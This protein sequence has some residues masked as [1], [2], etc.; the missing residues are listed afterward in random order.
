M[1]QYQEAISQADIDALLNRM[2]AF[3]DAMTKE[4]HLLNRGFVTA[5]GG[6]NMAHQFDARMLIQTQWQPNALELIFVGVTYLE[7]KDASEYW[8]AGGKFTRDLK[9]GQAQI[10][11]EFDNGLSIAANRLFWRERPDWTG[12]AARLGW[13]MP[14]PEAVP[15]HLIEGEWRQ[16]SACADAF[17]CSV[18]INYVRCPSCG[19]L[20]ELES[21]G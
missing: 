17:E 19:M 11:F 12:A 6:M 2:A 13:E 1:K 4:L 9:T 20:T 7:V 3:H 10:K 16:C 5:D 8:D 15:A 21:A 18:K 14:L